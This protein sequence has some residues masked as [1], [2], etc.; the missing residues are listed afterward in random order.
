DPRERFPQVLMWVVRQGRERR[1][2][3]DLRRVAERAIESLTKERVD[4]GEEGGE[5]LAR[6][7]GS[8]DQGVLTGSDERPGSPLWLGGLPEARFEPACDDG[9]KAREG[10]DLNMARLTPGRRPGVRRPT[11]PPRSP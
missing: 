6:A 5:R 3:D 2:V 9:V 10:H 8:R 4:R 11:H 1:H 7:G